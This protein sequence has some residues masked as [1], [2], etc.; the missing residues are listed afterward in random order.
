MNKPVMVVF[1]LMAVSLLGCS[2]DDGRPVVDEPDTGG[3]EEID[4]EG[5]DVEDIERPSVQAKPARIEFAEDV[6]VVEV[7]N[8]A[9]PEAIIRDQEGA[10]LEGVPVT[11]RSADGSILTISSGG[12]AVG[13]GLGQTTLTAKA[14]EVQA[15]WPA[16]V[17]AAKV[18]SLVIYPQQREIR[19][20]EQVQYMY[21]ARTET[22][23]PIDDLEG[24]SWSSEQSEV[25]S[26][27]ESGL[28][29]GLREGQ[30]QIIARIHECGG[31]G[32]VKREQRTCEQG[33][34]HVGSDLLSQRWSATGVNSVTL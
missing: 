34:H 14:G 15:A 10:I 17:V 25:A 32:T 9:R 2:G 21:E 1:F 31:A 29:K 18:A 11:W 4:G 30:T 22:N 24:L 6:F 19:I 16:E 20:D 27:D 5:G 3:L 7:D 28:A 12:V 23:A 26:I 33:H 8:T 13:V